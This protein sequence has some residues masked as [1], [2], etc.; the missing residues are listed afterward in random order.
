L[1]GTT[2]LLNAL[3]ARSVRR[4]RR[5]HCGRACQ[6]APAAG[7]DAVHFACVLAVGADE[8]VLAVWDQR[9]L[10]GAHRLGVNTAPA[11]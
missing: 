9:L 5:R 3:T 4:G 2:P 1:I 10:A 6:P 7:V 11:T 8:C